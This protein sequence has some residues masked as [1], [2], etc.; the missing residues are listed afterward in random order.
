MFQLRH[1]STVHGNAGANARLNINVIDSTKEAYFINIQNVF[2][3][4][5]A[6][7]YWLPVTQLTFKVW[8]YAQNTLIEREMVGIPCV[9]T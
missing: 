5:L 4:Q 7:F 1:N 3:A 2:T 6:R 9:S 8:R